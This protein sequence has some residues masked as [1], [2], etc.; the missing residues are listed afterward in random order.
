MLTPFDDTLHIDFNALRA[1]V[2]W[3][4][5]GGSQGLFACCLSS[6]MFHLSAQERSDLIL[7][8][9][10]FAKGRVPVIASGAFPPCVTL[11]DATAEPEAIAEAATKI[12]LSGA[13]AVVFTSNQFGN[14]HDNDAVWLS[15]L[16]KTLAFI[17]PAL[18][19]G[20]YE[21][22]TPYKRLLTPEIIRH[23]AATG[24]FRFIKDTC[25]NLPQIEAKVEACKGSSLRFYNANTATLLGSLRAGGSGFSGVG[26]NAIPHL[27]AWLCQNFDKQPD[28]AQALQAFLDESAPVVDDH[29]AHSVKYYLH[30]FGV[31][32]TKLS[33]TEAYNM[34]EDA[35]TVARFETFHKQVA[36]WE[37]RLGLTSPFAAVRG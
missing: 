27:Y 7:A 12:A 33:R 19:L 26:D 14:P 6:E 16:E 1:L 3:Y 35:A 36:H 10:E 34:V 17:D 11:K 22:P 29:Y 20:L 2:D 31:P 18:P 32:M 25:C 9:S 5:A 4:I 30:T 8:V 13:A 15:N 23:L 21:C 28:I 37:K 24:R